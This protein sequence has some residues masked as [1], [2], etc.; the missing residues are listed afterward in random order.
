MPAQTLDEFEID[1]KTERILN[2]QV[3]MSF[4][5]EFDIQ[6][7][8]ENEFI[9]NCG[10]KD[11]KELEDTYKEFEKIEQY[12]DPEDIEIVKIRWEKIT[13]KNKK[14]FD[15]AYFYALTHRSTLLWIG[16]AYQMNVFSAIKQEKERHK[17]NKCSI[18]LG[19]IDDT[20]WKNVSEK[21]VSD[22][23][24][25]LVY[26]NLPDE[27][28]KSTQS[29][30]VGR[31]IFVQCIGGLVGEKGNRSRVVKSVKCMDGKIS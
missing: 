7:D 10:F 11:K 24:A 19:Y 2:S 25:L 21:R 12:H 4:L 31:D 22:V 13:T 20:N 26:K 30:P 29:Y 18:W 1:D 8:E 6:D 9:E 14:Q 16:R 15:D 5:E 3:V 23:T 17:I 27:R 28:V